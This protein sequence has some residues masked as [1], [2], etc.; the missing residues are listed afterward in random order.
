MAEQIKQIN[1]L[2]GLKTETEIKLTKLQ[3][4]VNE[5]LRPDSLKFDKLYIESQAAITQNKPKEEQ[6]EL[7]KQM[8]VIYKKWTPIHDVL[9]LMN[10][11]LITLFNA[12]K[13]YIKRTENERT[14]TSLTRVKRV[15]VSPR[16]RRTRKAL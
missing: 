2:T 11:K 6:E 3:D 1:M 8:A 12:L 16:Q 13:A 5:V 9:D 10:P 15:S 4:E 7:Y 14:E